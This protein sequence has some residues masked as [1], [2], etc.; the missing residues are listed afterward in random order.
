[1][2]THVVMSSLSGF[3]RA[4]FFFK[5]RG[6]FPE[7][8]KWGSLLASTASSPTCLEMCGG[9]GRLLRLPLQKNVEQFV[10]RVTSGAKRGVYPHHSI[11]SLWVWCLYIMCACISI[12]RIRSDHVVPVL[13]SFSGGG[14]F[15]KKILL[16]AKCWWFSPKI[17]SVIPMS[18]LNLNG[19]KRLLPSIPAS[20]AVYYVCGTQ[21][22]NSLCA[23]KNWDF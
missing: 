21:I 9:S 18:H 1:M 7:H 3:L 4:F 13:Y 15:F 23:F 22:Q 10:M 8:S 11:N 5:A 20:C 6:F 12:S 16:G 19:V 14:E 2:I 17:Y